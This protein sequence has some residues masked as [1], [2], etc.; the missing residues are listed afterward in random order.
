MSEKV[1]Q[2]MERTS[3]GMYRQEL[4]ELGLSGDNGNPNADPLLEWGLTLPRGRLTSGPVKG[5]MDMRGDW[6]DSFGRL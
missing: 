3:Y 1:Q 2:V 4:V 5:C 6:I